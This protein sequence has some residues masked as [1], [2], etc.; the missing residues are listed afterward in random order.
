M[1]TSC[2]HAISAAISIFVGAPT[3]RGLKNQAAERNAEARGMITY[4]HCHQQRSV[5]AKLEQR[6][7]AMATE[8]KIDH[9]RRKKKGR[10]KK[11]ESNWLA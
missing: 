8:Q 11:G 5:D 6:C 2:P 1:A 10:E 4:T 3:P 7:E 9:A